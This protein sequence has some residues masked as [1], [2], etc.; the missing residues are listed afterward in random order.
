M[1][2]KLKLSLERQVLRG[3]RWL[4]GIVLYSTRRVALR[5]CAIT[6]TAMTAVPLAAQSETSY[7]EKS[8]RFIVPFSPGGGTDTIAR[9]VLDEL[10][11]TLG[12]PVIVEN[13]P[14]GSGMI[15]SAEVARSEPDGYTLLFTSGGPIS[16]NPSLY[17]EMAYD[18]INDFDPI[19]LGASYP[20]VLIASPNLQVKSVGELV[21]LAK[22]RPGELN[23][24]SGGIGTTQHL[25]GEML[26]SMAEIEMVHVPYKGSGP[27][28]TALLS[29]DVSVFFSTP[30]SAMPY[31]ENGDVV[32]LGVTGAEPSSRFPGVPPVSEVLEGFETVAWNGVFAP[33]GTP[34]EIVEKLHKEIAAAFRAPKVAE[35][36]EASGFN[37]VASS[38]EELSNFIAKDTE[39]WRNVV[40]HAGIEPQ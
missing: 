1:D 22:A 6:F 37:I 29:G 34:S 20:S 3:R 5:V 35:I 25:A 15:G 13:R 33:A 21:D 28:L 30:G 18:P 11:K 14:G 12:Q 32:A 36:I 9:V 17:A 23:F 40:D 39:R 7:P 4:E 26:N 24:A 27:A 16:I 19:T 8:I 10:S 31:I 38:P 2:Q